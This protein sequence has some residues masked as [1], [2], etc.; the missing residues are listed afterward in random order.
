MSVSGTNTAN[1]W[2]KGL[3]R[4]HLCRVASLPA[5]GADLSQNVTE[6]ALG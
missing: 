6:K 2:R 4:L 5:A 1:H 3:S